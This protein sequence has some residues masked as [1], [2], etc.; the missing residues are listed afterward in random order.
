VPDRD[1][2]ILKQGP[3]VRKDEKCALVAIILY[4]LDYYGHD[5]LADDSVVW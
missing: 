3:A 5:W 4:S 1:L 2:L